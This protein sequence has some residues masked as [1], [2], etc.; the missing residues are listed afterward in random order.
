MCYV[1]YF[2][3]FIAKE[4]EKNE[5]MREKEMKKKHLKICSYIIS[6]K[7]EKKNPRRSIIVWHFVQ[8]T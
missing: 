2:A 8:N 7:M 3:S 4:E 5:Q 1:F 6:E